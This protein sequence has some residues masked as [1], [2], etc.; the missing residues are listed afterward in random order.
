MALVLVLLLLLL[1]LL[2]ALLVAVV[3]NSSLV[4]LVVVPCTSTTGAML[5]FGLCVRCRECVMWAARGVSSVLLGGWEGREGGEGGAGF[6]ESYSKVRQ[7]LR[8]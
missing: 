1:M 8:P 6:C 3:G 7:N 4:L 2:P 5:C